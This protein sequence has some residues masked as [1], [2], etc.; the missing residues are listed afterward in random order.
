MNSFHHVLVTTFLSPS[1]TATFSTRGAYIM[2]KACR[3]RYSHSFIA[4]SSN[5][6]SPL[7]HNER[8]ARTAAAVDHSQRCPLSL[9]HERR[10][11]RKKTCTQGG[12]K[13]ANT[14]GNGLSS[15]KILTCHTC[16]TYT[17]VANRYHM[18]QEECPTNRIFI[19]HQTQQ[20]LTD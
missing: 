3:D 18:T 10:E 13:T 20:R 1:S 8:L 5:H 15:Q 12:A 4:N 16:P 14:V 19:C 17:P 11:T 9:I 6:Y 2:T 7:N